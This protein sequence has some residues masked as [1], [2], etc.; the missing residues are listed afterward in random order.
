VRRALGA[1]AFVLV[2]MVCGFA[3]HL[4][5]NAYLL[6]G[7]PLVLV[8]QRFVARRPLRALW[9]RAAPPPTANASGWTI[10]VA[11]AL[12]PLWQLGSALVSGLGGDIVAWDVCALGGSLGVAYACLHQSR[13]G[14]RAAIPFAALALFCGIF[15]MAGAAII[16]ARS[17][18]IDG[19][20]YAPFALDLLLY[21]PVAFVLEEVVFR[22]ALDSYAGGDGIVGWRNFLGAV[23]VAGLWGLWHLPVIPDPLHLHVVVQLLAVHIPIGVFLAFAWRRGGTLLLPALVHALVDAYRN[24]VLM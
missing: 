18:W 4:S 13:S 1:G 20:R 5:A 19:A 24:A 9:V 22:G 23:G 6:L 16:T 15:T 3:A 21:L 7:V 17:P 2:W 14:L 10:V 11:V 12:V 8:F